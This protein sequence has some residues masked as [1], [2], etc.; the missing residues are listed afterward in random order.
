M[1]V[2][3]RTVNTPPLLLKLQKEKKTKKKTKKRTLTFLGEIKG[4]SRVV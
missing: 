3:V 2:V 1:V 4:E